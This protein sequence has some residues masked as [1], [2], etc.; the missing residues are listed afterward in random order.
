MLDRDRWNPLV[1]L[2]GG[3][4]FGAAAAFSAVPAMVHLSPDWLGFYGS[5][6][7]GLVGG[8]LGVGAGWLAWAGVQ[9]QLKHSDQEKETIQRRSYALAHT[10]FTAAKGLAKICLDNQKSISAYSHDKAADFNFK[11]TFIE[12]AVDV[13]ERTNYGRNVQDSLIGLDIF[14]IQ[15][16]NI[17]NSDVWRL[18]KAS[19]ERPHSYS[20]EN[21]DEAISYLIRTIQAIDAVSSEALAI[22]DRPEQASPRSTRPGS[23]C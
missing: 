16:F 5:I 10:Y 3:T 21:I 14:T 23:R 1:L 6:A 22:I 17:C 8:L 12:G 19:K 7:G 15:L 2:A 9:A 18:S 13:F 11:L 20:A 4:V